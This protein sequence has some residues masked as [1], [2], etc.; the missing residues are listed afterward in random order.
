MDQT[1]VPLILAQ[2]NKI[3]RIPCKN[4]SCFCE[5]LINLFMFV[6][7]SSINILNNCDFILQIR[8]DY[9]LLYTWVPKYGMCIF[10]FFPQVEILFVR[11]FGV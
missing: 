8:A 2:I 10:L 11:V 5:L 9:P 3:D 4:A 6:P 1:I 7:P